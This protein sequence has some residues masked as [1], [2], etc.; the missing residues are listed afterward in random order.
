[1]WSVYL[2]A[3]PST[4]AKIVVT[5]EEAK[6]IDTLRRLGADEREYRDTEKELLKRFKTTPSQG[7]IVW[8]I[9]SERLL[10]AMK[11][12]N[13]QEMKML[14][15]QQARLLYELGSEFLIVL[16]EAAK[17]EL[18][19]YQLAGLKKVEVLTAGEQSCDKCSAL[20]GKVFTI[21]QALEVMPIPVGDCGKGWCRCLYAPVVD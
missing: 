21:E 19:D 12:G 17:C 2:R 16:Q 9:L 15:W 3:N 1:M 7:D 20:N 6:S 4:R 10:S 13:W 8:A 14:Y 18:R 5:E 11:Q